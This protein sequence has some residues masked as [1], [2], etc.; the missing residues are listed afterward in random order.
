MGP[1]TITDA[2]T[3]A[4]AVEA[5]APTVQPPTVE[6]PTVEG[7]AAGAAPA[8]PDEPAGPRRWGRR[9]RLLRRAG[10]NVVDQVLSALTN[11][12]LAF[13]VARS[14]D[15]PA[16]GAFAVSF[17]V[18]SL[19]I[20]VA[21]G[22]VGQPLAIRFSG[23][24]AQESTAAVAAGTGTVLAV[25]VPAGVALVAGGLLLGGNLGA[26]LWSLG[27]VLP[28]LVLQDACRMA[29]FAQ[30][31]A[32]LAAANDAL[33]AAVQF[34]AVAVLLSSGRDGVAELVLAWGGSA[35]LCAAVGLVQLRVLPR[36]AAALRWVRDHRDVSGYLVA[37][38]LL[39]A[40]AFHGGILVVGAL[41]GVEDIGALRAAQV[42]IGPLGILAAA[43]STFGLPEISR[44]PHLSA[45]TRWRVAVVAGALMLGASGAYTLL[46]LLVPQEVG[47][48][49]LGDTWSGAQDVLLPVA[50]GSTAAGAALGPAVVIYALGHARET[51]RLMVVE[52]PLVLTLMLLGSQ[53][54]G[55]RG[56]AWGLCIDQA[57]VVP[58][59]FLRLR[60][61]LGRGARHRAGR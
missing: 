38:Y 18:F 19:F 4:L 46:L 30:G 55:A 29:F 12:A 48:A 57:V 28:A 37:E 3:G 53:I 20:G 13:V 31:R 35:A 43:I 21:R 59:W 45:S 14:V 23:A 16:F 61:V 58:L 27:V 25:T 8:G 52:A 6:A 40:G 54:G 9:F 10:W 41:V 15:A 51:F 32:H 49:L 50:L 7:P 39:G 60:A 24:T 44:R 56:A 22:L 17:L 33:W 34:G 1:S 5:A 2:D 42:L 36:P 47:V 26:A 11:A